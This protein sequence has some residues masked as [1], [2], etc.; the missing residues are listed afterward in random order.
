MGVTYDVRMPSAAAP[1]AP[2]TRERIVTAA[3]TYADQHGLPELSMRRLAK[4]VGFEVMSL[5]NHVANKD[6]LLDAMVD[7]VAGEIAL[8]DVEAAGGWKHAL[9]QSAISA[10]QRLTR[11][12]WAGSLWGNRMPGPNRLRLMDATLGVLASAGL[13]EAMADHGF[14]ALTNHIVGYTLQANT[15]QM[16]EDLQ[17]AGTE[18]VSAIVEDYPHLADHVRWHVETDA[19]DDESDFEFVLDL[20]LEGLHTPA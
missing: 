13:G 18:F 11:H 16:P 8:P 2:L 14:H 20:I 9:R 5:Y 19:R 3:T 4:E 17:S 15:L 7:Q 6:D 12:R 1:R 10:H